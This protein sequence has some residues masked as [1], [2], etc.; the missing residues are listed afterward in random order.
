MHMR[1][2]EV[3]ADVFEQPA[4]SFGEDSSQEN[5]PYWTSLGHVKLL[6]A[7]ETRFG[8]RFSNVEMATMRSL[9]DIRAVLSRRG[10]LVA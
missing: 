1:L 9:G 3:F 6:V 2:E 5:V 7:I 8:I 4:D 10:A